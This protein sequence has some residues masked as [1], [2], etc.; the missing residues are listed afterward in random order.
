MKWGYW[1][2]VRTSAQNYGANIFGILAKTH[3][4]TKILEMKNGWGRL[5]VTTLIFY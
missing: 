4:K 1:K 2:C 5:T 3:P